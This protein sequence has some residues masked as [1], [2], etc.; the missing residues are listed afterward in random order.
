MLHYDRP[1]IHAHVRIAYCVFSAQVHNLYLVSG[2]IL[3]TQYHAHIS[4]IVRQYVV[5]AGRTTKI[6]QKPQP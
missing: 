4:Q 2:T 5:R 6:I 3:S 1:T